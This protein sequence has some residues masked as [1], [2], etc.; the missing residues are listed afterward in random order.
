[1]TQTIRWG[2]IGVGN[3]T[4]QK[5]GPG[6]QQAQH[7]QLVAVMRRNA[8][9]AEDYATRHKVPFWTTDASELINHPEVDAVYIATPPD[10]HC[11]YT[12]HVAAAGKPV[13][14]EKPMAR[15]YAECQ[16]MLRACEQ[17]SV[18]LFVAYYRRAMP[19]FERVRRIIE[20]GDL[21][22][23]RSV[24]ITLHRP[25]SSEDTSSSKPWRVLPEVAGGGYFVDM[26]SHTLDLL[27]W[28]LGPITHVYGIA[29]NQA[30]HYPA[31]DAVSATFSF[32]N[33]IIGSGSWCF[34]AFEQYDE[35]TITGDTGCLK[36]SCFDET[37]LQLMTTEGQQTIDA[38]YPDVVQQP[39]I[40][41]VVNAL[42]GKGTCASTG[43]SAAR[44]SYVMDNI[45]AQYRRPT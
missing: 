44:T 5:S 36:F 32:E 27:D 26:G 22:S 41:Q 10:S 34:N 7:S 35:V 2:I 20:A 30:G 38:P 40:Q 15:T 31:E 3:V 19:R 43:Q 29:Q 6:F 1:M 11:S 28:L 25:A 37:A 4:E 39:L 45:L 16:T 17:A 23:V 24:H 9:R 14:V 18:P 21:G 8:A 13:Y 33:G 42:N 12:E